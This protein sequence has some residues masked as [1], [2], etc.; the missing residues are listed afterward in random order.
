MK[1]SPRYLWFEIAL[2]F[3]VGVA[4]ALLGVIVLYVMVAVSVVV[5]FLLLRRVRRRPVA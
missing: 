2:M 5:P 4:G 3:I 1:M